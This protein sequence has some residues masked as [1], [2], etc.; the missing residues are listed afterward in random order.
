[1]E[2]GFI[3]DH[4]HPNWDHARE[5]VWVA[6]KPQMGWFSLKLPDEK[7]PVRAYRCSQCGSLELFAKEEWQFPGD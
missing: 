1:M 7:I 5:A 4:S 6:G 2:P 3:P